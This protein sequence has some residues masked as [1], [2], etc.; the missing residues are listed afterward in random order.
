MR[1]Q[2]NDCIYHIILSVNT[3][4]YFS[5]TR[6]RDNMISCIDT[7]FAGASTAIR[8]AKPGTWREYGQMEVDGTIIGQ[9]QP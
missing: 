1:V 2:E 6:R 4:F 8:G 5:N 7:H 3:G 9:A